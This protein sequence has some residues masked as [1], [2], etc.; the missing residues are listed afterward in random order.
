MSIN[1]F[2]IDCGNFAVR[3]SCYIKLSE[4]ALY[5]FYLESNDGSKLYLDDNLI[6]DNDGKVGLL[7]IHWDFM[8]TANIALQT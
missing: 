8:L 6:V 3:F 1:N 4:T 7:T 5:T 2:L